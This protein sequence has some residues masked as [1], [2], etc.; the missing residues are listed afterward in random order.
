MSE[1]KTYEIRYQ[2][3]KVTGTTRADRR[4][5]MAWVNLETTFADIPRFTLPEILD[6]VYELLNSAQIED[7]QMKPLLNVMNAM[8]TVKAPVVE[9]TDGIYIRARDEQLRIH[10]WDMDPGFI[11]TPVGFVAFAIV[12]VKGSSVLNAWTME[13]DQQ[14]LF[15]VQV[16]LTAVSEITKLEPPFKYLATIPLNLNA[17]INEEKHLVQPARL[18]AVQAPRFYGDA[19]PSA[20]FELHPLTLDSQEW[21]QTQLFCPLGPNLETSHYDYDAI[22]TFLRRGLEGLRVKHEYEND[23]LDY[24][25]TQQ[26]RA[27]TALLRIALFQIDQGCA[28]FF[29][30][31]AYLPKNDHVDDAPFRFQLTKEGFQAGHRLLRSRLTGYDVQGVIA[32]GPTIEGFDTKI[33]MDTEDTADTS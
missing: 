31:I 5:K 32:I 3:V 22:R 2:C 33:P 15:M 18:I 19:L 25:R 29:Q 16:P 7:V 24:I 6:K 27:S 23:A 10:H 8:A 17:I 20:Q 21:A 1:I 12:T 28:Y 4:D 13:P 30:F 26:P 14:K 9:M 11:I